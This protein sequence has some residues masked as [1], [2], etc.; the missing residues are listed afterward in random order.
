M[1]IIS[2]R[3]N[4]N[5]RI[6][7]KENHP[8]YIDTALSSGYDVEIDIWFRDEKFYL[9]HDIPQYEI[10]INWIHDRENKLW[11]HAKNL[12]AV[13]QLLKTELNWFWHDTDK[14]TITS[15]GFPWAYTDTFFLGSYTVIKNEKNIPEY[16]KGI[17]TDFPIEFK[18]K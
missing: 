6:P 8:N 9:G 15:K 3:G 2:H 10:D 16:V 13:E 5:G 4:L 18:K 14:M 1:K 11:I 7:E 12:G 17:C